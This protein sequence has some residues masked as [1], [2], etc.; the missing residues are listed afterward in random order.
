[1]RPTPAFDVELRHPAT[2]AGTK[3]DHYLAGSMLNGAITLTGCPALSIP[4]G[5]DQF[6]RPIGLQLVAPPHREDRLLQ[7]AA[8]FEMIAGFGQSVPI[9]PR[10][11]EVPP[12]E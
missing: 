1:M 6:G 2:I 10:S 4:C 12:S 3:L 8:L 9:D 7:A 5:L 11:G